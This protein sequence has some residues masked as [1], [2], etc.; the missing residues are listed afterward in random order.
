MQTCPCSVH[1]QPEQTRRGRRRNYPGDSSCDSPAAAV[2]SWPRQG[3]N[4]RVT[5]DYRSQLPLIWRQPWVTWPT[6][7]QEPPA[8]MDSLHPG[9]YLHSL[10]EFPLPFFYPCKSSLY[11]C[12]AIISLLWNLGQF[13]SYVFKFKRVARIVPGSPTAQQGKE[14]VD[15]PDAAVFGS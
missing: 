3:E 4:V 2:P 13:N 14:L 9:G 10:P 5:L 12:V 6:V 15:G 7:R 11:R 8:F 1:H